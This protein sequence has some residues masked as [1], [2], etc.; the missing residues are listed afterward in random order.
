MGDSSCADSN[1]YILLWAKQAQL[2]NLNQLNPDPAARTTV[3][4]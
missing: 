1:K 3:Q 2:P 4:L